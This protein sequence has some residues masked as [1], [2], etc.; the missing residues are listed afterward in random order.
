[1]LDP[2][3]PA[4]Y[5]WRVKA[6]AGGGTVTSATGTFRIPPMPTLTAVSPRTGMAGT[7]ISETLTGTNFVA[8]AT[9]VSMSGAGVIVNG[10]SV[11][12][13]TTLTATVVIDPTAGLGAR[14]VTVTTADGTS[15]AETFTVTA[16]ELVSL[17]ASCNP[18]I[19]WSRLGTSQCAVTGLYSN[20]KSVVLT[21]GVTW[22]TSDATDAPV[23]SSGLVTS[24][25]SSSMNVS[26][27]ATFQRLSASFSL[28]LT[29]CGVIVPVCKG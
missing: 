22:Q 6:A 2:L 14:Q 12:S 9:T 29:G 16:P 7:T 8:G 23:D 3:P 24:H 20:G 28:H 13:S 5:Y 17:T 1:M 18:T 15:V 25:A 21:S 10:V 19:I 27:T 11:T 26:I 4:T